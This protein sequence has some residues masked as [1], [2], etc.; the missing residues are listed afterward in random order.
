MNYCDMCFRNVIYYG[1]IFPRHD[2]IFDEYYK[3]VCD[4]DEVIRFPRRPLPDPYDGMCDRERDF[5]P[6]EVHE[7]FEKLFE[8]DD[9]FRKLFQFGPQQ[10]HEIV[11]L[12]KKVGYNPEKDG[13]LD[14]WLINRAYKMIEKFEQGS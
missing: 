9:E 10:G 3:I 8:Y 6:K 1:E 14:F 5:A 12:C 4:H 7:K 13:W 11:E 2:L